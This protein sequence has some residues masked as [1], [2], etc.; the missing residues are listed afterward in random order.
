M[1][2]EELRIHALSKNIVLIHQLS[3]FLSK[4]TIYGIRRYRKPFYKTLHR[5]AEAYKEIY[6]DEREI[7]D[8]ELWLTE[9]VG[10]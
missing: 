2:K 10:K 3:F 6:K 5:F 8:I 7:R 9:P 4:K 1:E